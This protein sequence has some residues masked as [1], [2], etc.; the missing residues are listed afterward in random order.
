[1]ARMPKG[2]PVSVPD[3]A[4]ELYDEMVRR[5]QQDRFSPPDRRTDFSRTSRGGSNVKIDGQWYRSMDNGRTNVL[6]PAGDLS[7]TPA[8]LAQQQ[9][10]AREALFDA[11]NT[12][13]G[14]AVGLATLAGASLSG[15]RKA[16]VAGAAVD[17][18]LMGAAT[19]ARSPAISATLPELSQSQIR[20]S[21]RYG[22]LNTSG[23]ATGVNATVTAPMLGTGTRANPK[24]SPPGWR[25]NGSFNNEARGHLYANNLGGSGDNIRNLV[26][27]TQQPMNS[28]WMRDFE[29]SVARRVR[30][31]EVVEYF[32]TPLYGKAQPPA[33][34]LL[35]AHGS[36]G[37]T[38]GV[39]VDNPAG[40]R[41]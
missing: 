9:Q 27:Q 7:L 3:P 4:G 19:R 28:P 6:V 32:A 38:S 15:R 5:A 18:A 23:Q 20:P 2:E 22:T 36:R 16:R 10:A 30:N 37:K 40:R 41:K 25:G 35:M 26:T 39:I 1:M 21:V 34:I 29:L 17:A 14:V 33:A 12:M 11:N 8:E 13:A 24:L 31:G